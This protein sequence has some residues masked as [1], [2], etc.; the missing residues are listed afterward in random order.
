MA[1]AQVK[2]V[3]VEKKPFDIDEAMVRLRE[4]VTPFP[5]AAL[6]QLADEGFNSAFEQLLACMI[7]IRTLDE[8][9]LTSSRRLFAQA[10]TPA[11]LLA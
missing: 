2:E 11:Q 6:F 8:T 5:A 3:G 7:S 9:T 1:G 10:R 4:A